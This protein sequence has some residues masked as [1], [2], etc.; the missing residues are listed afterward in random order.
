M[1]SATSTQV[2]G[3]F[4]VPQLYA[5]TSHRDSA[6]LS[7]LSH[8]FSS[9]DTLQRQNPFGFSPGTSPAPNDIK[10]ERS[11][12][13]YDAQI[14]NS[15]VGQ[16]SYLASHDS[17]YRSPLTI[18]PYEAASPQSLHPP[19]RFYIPSA[20]TKQRH[21]Q[22]T[23]PSESTPTGGRPS[24]TTSQDGMGNPAESRNKPTTRKRRNTQANRVMGSTGQPAATLRRRKKAAG[25]QSSS[26]QAADSN[27]RRSQ[28]LER[29]RVAASKCRLK[30]K[31]WT[32]NLEQ[33]ARELQASKASLALL[34]SSLR[35]ELLYLKGEAMRHETCDCN[36]IREYL[37]RHA[38]DPL[39]RNPLEY[40]QSPHSSSSFSFDAMALNPSISY[41]SPDSAA[42]PNYHDLPELDILGQIPD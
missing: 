29:N 20:A 14:G 11:R 5:A 21:G 4:G 13:T 24:T 42:S 17:Q 40:A 25:K 19:G 36:S 37:A 7:F 12:S 18:P 27:D 22:L 9:F 3:D 15:S 31:E 41:D 35:H 34:V 1:S 30:K 6:E 38:D 33:R 39:S 26:G 2:M 32:S 23:P 8:N 28:F 10:S 16:P